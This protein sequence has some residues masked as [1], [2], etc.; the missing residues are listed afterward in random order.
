MAVNVEHSKR[1][2]KKEQLYMLDEEQQNWCTLESS[3][4]KQTKRQ[5]NKPKWNIEQ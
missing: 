2:Q 3:S 5:K 4:S 1:T